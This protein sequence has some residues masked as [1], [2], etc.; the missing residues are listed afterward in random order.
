MSLL[1]V[2]VTST[3]QWNTHC[4]A[5]ILCPCLEQIETRPL[6]KTTPTRFAQHHHKT[7][8]WV[9]SSNGNTLNPGCWFDSRDVCCDSSDPPSLIRSQTHKPGGVLEETIEHI[10][11]NTEPE[12]N[13]SC[14]KEVEEHTPPSA[15]RG[16][17]LPS[18]CPVQCDYWSQGRLWC[19]KY[20]RFSWNIKIRPNPPHNW[21]VHAHF[22]LKL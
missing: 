2:G 21:Q 5:S 20:A 3:D 7:T 11:S 19:A 14:N 4:S 16:T 12:E 6:T 8:W 17:A 18:G 22:N 10:S 9:L 15:S 1:D 13:T